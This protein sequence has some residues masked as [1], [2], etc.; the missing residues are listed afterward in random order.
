MIK[1][2]RS[3]RKVRSDRDWL[4]HDTYIQANLRIVSKVLCELYVKGRGG[5]MSSSFSHSERA[6]YS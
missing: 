2:K 5:K 6:A 3:K 1:M 4:L